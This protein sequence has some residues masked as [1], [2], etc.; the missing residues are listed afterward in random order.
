MHSGLLTA[1]GDHLSND[2]GRWRD[3]V[4]AAGVFVSSAKPAVPFHLRTN[5]AAQAV[6]LTYDDESLFAEAFASLGGSSEAE[7]TPFSPDVVVEVR[8]HSTFPDFAYFHVSRHGVPVAAAEYFFGFDHPDGPFQQLATE[9]GWTLARKRTADETVPFL[10]VRG[11]HCFIRLTPEWTTD[12]L[13]FV[14]RAVF[15]VQRDALLFH[16]AAVNIAGRGVMIV[17]PSGAGKTT[18]A[19]ALAARGH[20]ILTDEVSWYVPS[21]GE[22]LDFRRPV[23]IREGVRPAA[24][25]AALERAG[26]AAV[27]WGGSRRLFVHDLLPQHQPMSRVRLEVVVVLQSFSDTPVLTRITPGNQHLSLLRPIPL[28]MLNASPARRIMQVAQ[29]LSAV[30]MYHLDLG[31]PDKTAEILEEAVLHDHDRS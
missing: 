3:L 17:G 26:A 2:T 6:E 21:T 27:N 24:L 1:A 14:F 20:D 19:L 8:A 15:A 5:L 16:A 18:T 9:S 28:S 11:P 10:I 22:L 29:L 23:G 31:H 13:S 30:R 7:P 4:A 25:D 12:V